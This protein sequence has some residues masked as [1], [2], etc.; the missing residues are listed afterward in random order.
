MLRPN[1]RIAAAF[2][3]LMVAIAM[4][5][6]GS[7]WRRF[8]ETMDEAYYIACGMQWLSTGNF[9]YETQNPPLAKV[10]AAVGPYF[11]GARFHNLP[12]AAEEGRAI[13]DE[14]PDYFGMLARARAGNLLFFL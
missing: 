11:S 4:A 1:G 14:A 5:R 13:L 7:T 8:T 3:V 6:I 2:V 12:N 9:T 10:V